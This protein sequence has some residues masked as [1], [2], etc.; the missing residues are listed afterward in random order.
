MSG[1]GLDYA[2]IPVAADIYP[3]GA[4]SGDD[5]ELLDL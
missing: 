5:E 1:R 2:E 3:S 4:E